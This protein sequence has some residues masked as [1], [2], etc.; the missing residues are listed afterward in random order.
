[1]IKEFWK[2]KIKLDFKLGLGL[3]IIFSITRFIAVMYGI[4]S[5]DNKYLPIVFSAMI[6]LPFVL[7]NKEG[8]VYS[9]LKKP[10]SLLSILKSLL[11]GTAACYLVF[12]IG[13]LLYG[14]DLLNWFRYIGES[15]PIDFGSI[16][17]S[18]KKIYFFVFI[19]IGMTFSPFGEE[20]LYRGMIHSSFIKKYGERRSAII[21]S[22]AFGVV[23]LAHYG[24]I[25]QNG[26]WELKLIPSLIWILLMFCTGLIFNYCKKFSD[27]I[28]GAIVA[29]MG[30]NIT[31]TYLI[32][33]S[34]FK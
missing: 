28:W 9:K 14:N 8:R 17:N 16:S 6:I 23:H 26:T 12:L 30:F 13:Q 1:M 21:D 2:E 31:M 32:F 29:H 25:Y 33:Y 5:G 10:N 22:L 24:F 18:D 7:L 19:I 20:I 11:L 15:Y 27:S 4:Q 34:L 3:I